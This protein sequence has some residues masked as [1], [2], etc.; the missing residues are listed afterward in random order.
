MVVQQ[1]PLERQVLQGRME[2]QDEMVL[3]VPMACL[4]TIHQ[5]S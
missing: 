4:V 3:Q 2:N 1:V 5:L